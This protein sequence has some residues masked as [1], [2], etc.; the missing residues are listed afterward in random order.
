MKRLALAG[1]ALA[2]L[3]AG[4]A[5][6]AQVTVSLGGYTEFFAAI[7]ND[8]VP[9][10][11]TGREFEIDTEIVIRA[12]GKADNGLLYGAKVEIQNNQSPAPGVGTDEASVYLAGT[13]GRLELGDFDG[14]SDSLAIYAPVVGIEQIDGEY[15][16]F[17]GVSTGGIRYGEGPWGAETAK[18]PDS[19]D[20]TKIMY[21]TPRVAGFQAG[22]SYA[23]ENGSEGQAV[24]ALKPNTGYKDFLEF[25]AN[26]DNAIEGIKFTLS[27]TGSTAS[28]QSAG[29]TQQLEDFLTWQVG[30]KV[31]YAGL[32]LGG[33]YIDADDFNKPTAGALGGDQYSWNVGIGYTS[34]PV[35]VAA[36]Y[37]KAEG[38][39]RAADT[40]AND[41][42][43]Y[44]VGLA[45]TMAPGLVLE[46]DLMFV[47]ERLTGGTAA[48]PVRTD[49]D[50]YVWMLATRLNF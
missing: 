19:G 36:S 50:G 9:G 20:S 3:S 34:G 43:L 5:A 13:W 46:S 39:K 33:S 45:Y 48:A 22:I 15:E 44:G 12:D 32:S 16:D 30:G 25:G 10:G 2:A 35:A 47:D 24:T 21:L 1:S 49:N 4:S 11:R 26:Y 41:Y 6:H 28:G 29:G 18:T 38:Y 23:P 42:Q 40:F 17:L 27:A 7:Y 31:S 14:A 37:L 8:D